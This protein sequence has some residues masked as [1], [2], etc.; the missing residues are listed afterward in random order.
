MRCLVTGGAGFLGSHLV[1][2]LLADGHDVTVLDD[3]S[4]GH[5]SNLPSHR[6]VTVWNDDI[7]SPWDYEGDWLFHLAGKADIVPSIE[8]PSVYHTVNVNGTVSALQQA[9]M[10]GVTRF[11][12]A[13]SSSCYGDH[14]VVPTPEDAPLSPRYPY[15]LT[16]MV[17]EEYA[18]HWMQVYGLPVVSLRLF[19]VYGQR[20]RTSGA[21][22]A[23]MGVF[24][25]Q[26]ANGKPLTV[27]GDG[28]Q[29]RDF[30]HVSD[31][32]EAMVKAAES[33][34]TGVFNVGSGT[35]PSI[36]ELVELFDAP[37]VHIPK[38]PGE[39]DVTLADIRK[40]QDALGWVPRLRFV[41]GVR[42]L[43]A[44]LEEWKTAPIW[45]PDTIAAQTAAWHRYLAS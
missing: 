31:V 27:V 11:I 5:L 1:E 42:D 35:A 23:V 20:H 19:N 41:D 14:P 25:A 30:T 10:G 21:Y 34:V 3:F 44:H 8:S 43:L 40:I 7:R 17:A 24:L 36:N 13:A 6:R 9:L 26:K 32:V 16:K 4:T 18:L 29:R 38:R 28:M 22:G 45:T 12:Y 39:P 15:A 2:R 37:A 33:D